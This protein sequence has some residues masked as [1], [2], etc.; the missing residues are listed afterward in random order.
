MLFEHTRP[1]AA[2]YF[3]C[4]LNTR[5]AHRDPSAQAA[6]VYL[7]SGAGT[8]KIGP[9]QGKLER[10]GLL[11]LPVD[12]PAALYPL[13]HQALGYYY[14]YLE[15]D[16]PN[17]AKDLRWPWD[18]GIAWPNGEAPPPVA[19]GDFQA[20]V[21]GLV[22]R[23]QDELARR[24]TGAPVVARACLSLLGVGF[25]RMLSA[26]HEPRA[27]GP[28]ARTAPK[29]GSDW[30]EPVARAV[31]FVLQNLDR[32]LSL[33]ELA[34]VAR[35]SERRLVQLFRSALGRSP[36]AYVRE[37]RVREAQRLL[38]QGGM[39]IKEVA[40]RL[41]FADPQHFCRVFRQATG[42]T[43]SDYL[44]GRAPLKQ[45][46]ASGYTPSSESRREHPRRGSGHRSVAASHS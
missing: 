38:M 32:D 37:Q 33:L 28:A 2:G 13:P 9:W 21:A 30:P 44:A 34:R 22:R 24:R 27:A 3:Q 43:P 15:G 7:A 18:L 14:V 20:S 10:G 23:I 35:Y 26:Q 17:G 6:L 36:M 8:W 12:L 4:D 19:S 40:L 42:I 25:A 45:T 31:D 39:T 16:G 1:V 29:A 41:N 5:R 11:A 46:R